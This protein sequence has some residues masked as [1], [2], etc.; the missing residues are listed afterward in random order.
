MSGTNPG[1]QSRCDGSVMVARNGDTCT[2]LWEVNGVEFP[3]TGPGAAMVKGVPAMG[4]ASEADTA[5][6]VG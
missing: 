1:G 4:P 6:A 5:I 2:V 3:G